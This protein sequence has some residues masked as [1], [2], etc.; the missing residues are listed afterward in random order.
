MGC[1]NRL[2]FLPQLQSSNNLFFE[3][4]VLKDLSYEVMNTLILF[5]K[6]NITTLF[7]IQRKF[8]NFKNTSKFE[9]ENN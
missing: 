6:Q 3:D 9:K 5:F 2:I 7:K 8:G 4:Y 1:S